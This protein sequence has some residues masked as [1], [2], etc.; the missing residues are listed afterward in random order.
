[1]SGQ[2]SDHIIAYLYTN[3]SSQ[4]VYKGKQNDKQHI[5]KISEPISLAKNNLK[6]QNDR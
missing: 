6:F 1:M 2:S 4:A 5:H 3:L